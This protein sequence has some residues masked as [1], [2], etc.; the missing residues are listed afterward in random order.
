MEDAFSNGR[1]IKYFPPLYKVKR[2]TPIQRKST[3]SVKEPVPVINLSS[4]RKNS[5]KKTNKL[6]GDDTSRT[7]W[8]SLVSNQTTTHFTS[9]F[10]YDNSNCPSVSR[11]TGKESVSPET[12][13]TVFIAHPH[14]RIE[15]NSQV[16]HLSIEH[17]EEPSQPSPFN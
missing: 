16:V 1:V 14:T 12:I 5:P 17:E 8:S 13:L 7:F 11:N 6:P 3:N 10:E 9:N 4:S 2:Y 15:P